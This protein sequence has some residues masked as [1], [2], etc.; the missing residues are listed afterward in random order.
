MP[1]E[2]PEV[3][4]IRRDLA[5]AVVGRRITAVFVHDPAVVKVPDPGAFVAGLKGR[6]IEAADRA[7][8]YLLLP[9]DD[10][11]VWAVHLSLE[12]RLLLVPASAEV[13]NGTKLAVALDDGHE[14]RLVDPVS[15]ALVALVEVGGLAEVFS[16]NLLGPEPI[17][18]GFDEATLRARLAGRRGMIKPLILNQRIIAG[19]GNIYADEALWRAKIHPSR[20]ANGL[21]DA[22]WTALHRALVDTLREGV[23][24]RGTTAPGGL[25]RDLWGKKG[26]HQAHLA[27][28]RRAGKA[29]PRC[30][31]A[32]VR[33]ELGGRPTFFCPHCQPA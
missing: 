6:T 20:K 21:T 28:F 30:G 24:N 22:E 7:A 14:L 29:C 23:A 8:K 27:V 17:H 3:E 10:G 13:A 11:R 18:P 32:I 16:L 15:Y 1:P 31:T 33:T 4:T 26:A 5:E 2:L 25:Y 19:V 9:L 12:G